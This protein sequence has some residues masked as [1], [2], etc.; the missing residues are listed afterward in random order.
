[1]A[2]SKELE[3]VIEAALA[4]GVITEK[5][6]A[7]LHKKALQEGV[8]PDE[9]DVV[10]DGRLAKMKREVDWL[11]PEP[12]RSVK[13]GNLAKCPSCGAPYIPGTGKCPECGHIFQ[14]AEANHSAQRLAD[15][16]EQITIRFRDKIASAS[17]VHGK[18]EGLFGTLGITGLSDAEE[19]NIQKDKEIENY[20]TNFVIPSSK[21]DLLEFI[22]SMDAKKNNGDEFRYVYNVKYEEACKKARIMF[23]DDPQFATLLEAYDKENASNAKKKVMYGCLGAIGFIVLLILG[24]LFG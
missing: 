16:I 17:N 15:G 9:V 20:I 11:R 19:L 24:A 22:I 4:D 21:D 18:E 23:P 8:D 14:N 10:M 6:R 2:F 5:E 12:P 1:M 13:R 7:V 3:E